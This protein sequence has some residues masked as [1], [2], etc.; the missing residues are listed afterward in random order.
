MPARATPYPTRRARG[1][2]LVEL[3]VAVMI[4]VIMILAFSTVLSQGQ[5]VV[6][7]S[8]RVIRSNAQAA[9]VA[10][11][12]RRDIA[13]ITT[14]GFLYINGSGTP[15]LLFTA[16]GHFMARN[17]TPP[18][19]NI[20]AN[21]AVICYSAAASGNIL[22]RE[23]H[24]LT[25]TGQPRGS[26]DVL[27]IYLSDITSGRSGCTP[28]NIRSMFAT[29]PSVTAFPT[30]LTEVENTWPVL[31]DSCSNITVK[32]RTVTAGGTL[33]GWVGNAGTWTH[34]NRTNWP[35]LIKVSFDVS[36]VHHEIT[37]PVGG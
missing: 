37:C 35:V 5:A 19:T 26:S 4:L 28:D 31:V 17:P 8:Q 15:A 14:D 33:G 12:L 36:G 32:Y 11:V 20:H 1:V 23:A 22:C 16:A 18:D 24:L 2:T 13:S 34:A 7:A 10:Q 30:T 29:A 21:A 9:A 25:N 3:M 27:Q 6:T